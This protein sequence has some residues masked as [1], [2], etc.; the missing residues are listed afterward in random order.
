MALAS[1]GFDEGLVPN[2]VEAA[3]EPRMDSDPEE[4]VVRP[5]IGLSVLSSPDSRGD[6][7]AGILLNFSRSRGAGD[8]GRRSGERGLRELEDCEE[9]E[10]DLLRGARGACL[11]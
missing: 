1:N 6:F 8:T 11:S 4:E 3:A 10:I 2:V 7:V 5:V 9:G